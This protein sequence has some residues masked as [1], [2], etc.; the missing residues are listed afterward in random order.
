M[1]LNNNVEARL[2][3]YIFI[4]TLLYIWHGV[5]VSLVGWLVGRSVGRSRCCF[6]AKRLDRS[7][8]CLV[9]YRSWPQPTQQCAD[10]VE[11]HRNVGTMPYLHVC[12]TSLI[13]QRRYFYYPLVKVRIHLQRAKFVDSV[14]WRPA[15][16]DVAGASRPLK[17]RTTTTTW[18][19]TLPMHWP[20][21]GNSD[22]RSGAMATIRH[23]HTRQTRSVTDI[24]G[25]N[26]SLFVVLVSRRCL[27]L[28]ACKKEA[29]L[30]KEHRWGAHLPFIGR[31]ARKW[32]NIYCLW[33][34]ASAT[35]D[36]RLPSQPK[37]VLIAPTHGGMAR[38]IWPGWLVT[39]RDSLP[40][41]RRS[42][43]HVLTRPDVE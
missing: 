14:W 4:C 5:T 30:Q 41:R 29:I 18:N 32:I 9:P 6:M 39:Y 40:A 36:L 27:V 10:E 8:G 24:H 13:E 25:R 3:L 42:P 15:D 22:W 26:F 21:S 1:C 7:N 23:S 11:K 35:P 34:I 28:P 37:L 31:W 33:R 19:V 17:T 38:L 16:L 2:A 43:I 20:S 12:I